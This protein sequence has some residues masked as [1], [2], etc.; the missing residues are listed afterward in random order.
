MTKKENH[1]IQM[2]HNRIRESNP[3]AG[4]IPRGSRARGQV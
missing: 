1:I 3:G 4:A 2:I